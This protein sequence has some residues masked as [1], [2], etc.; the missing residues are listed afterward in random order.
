MTKRH[1]STTQH[2]RLMTTSSQKDAWYAWYRISQHAVTFSGFMLN[3]SETC[4]SESSCIFKIVDSMKNLIP[5]DNS[6]E[7]QHTENVFIAIHLFL[8]CT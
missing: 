4:A 5:M 3:T 8:I 7:F 2:K 6:V 1:K